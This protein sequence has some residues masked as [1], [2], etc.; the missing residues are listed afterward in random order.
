MARC[1]RLR[2][3]LRRIAL[4]AVVG[5]LA[6]GC[7]GSNKP[8][9][10][11]SDTQ[12]EDEDSLVAPD[13]LDVPDLVPDVPVRDPGTEVDAADVPEDEIGPVEVFTEDVHTD[14]GCE[15]DS[16]CPDPGPCLVGRCVDGICSTEARDCQDGDPC[17][18]DSCDQTTGCAHDAISG[19]TTCGVSTD[20][21]GHEPNQCVRGSCGLLDAGDASPP[22]PSAGSCPDGLEC[23]P[24][25][26]QCVAHACRW[27]T[28][29]CDDQDPCTTDGCDPDRGCTHVQAVDAPPACHTCTKDLDCA[30][31]VADPCSVI[32]CYLTSGRCR[33]DP[34]SCDDGNQCTVDSCDPATGCLHVEKVCNDGDSCTTD[35]C[36]PRHR[37][38]RRHR[39]V[40]R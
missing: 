1:I 2:D 15:I 25:S 23:S 19:C 40:V 8:K 11:L 28:R 32:T 9:D 18:K 13:I 20:C 30:N 39:P 22:C 38:M 12:G 6:S 31:L 24:D 5:A 16:D 33:V 27:I 7:G 34:K 29:V 36:N 37:H 14:A 3:S 17:T 35:S 21:I 26:S 10:V 4:L